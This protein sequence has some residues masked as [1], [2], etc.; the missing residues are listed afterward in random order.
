MQRQIHAD[1]RDGDTESSVSSGL[2]PVYSGSKQRRQRM[3][4]WGRSV[5]LPDTNLLQSTSRPESSVDSDP[6][7]SWTLHLLRRRFPSSGKHR[8]VDGPGAASER[9]DQYGRRKAMTVADPDH[10]YLTCC[11]RTATDGIRLP[12][13]ADIKGTALIRR[14]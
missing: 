6:A 2:D 9:R 1:L 8:P 14:R 13:A 4:Q 11:R 3:I 10:A 7:A 12:T 5:T